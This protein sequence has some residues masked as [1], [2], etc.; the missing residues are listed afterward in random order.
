MS[1]IIREI[2]WQEYDT[3]TQIGTVRADII[4][5]AIADLPS[6]GIMS[7][8]KLDIGSSAK[9]IADGSEWEIQSSGSWVR[10]PSKLQLDL[11]GYVT[12]QDLSDGLAGKVDNTTYSAGQA[13]QDDLI[14]YAID[15]GAKNL[16]NID[17]TPIVNH[18]DYTLTDGKLTVSANG[19]WAHYS[20]P[21]NL[22]AGSYILSTVISGYSKASGAPDTSMRL[23][24]SATTSGGTNV[25]LYTITGNGAI[26]VPFTWTG[27]T[28]YLQFYSN[29][30]TT[31]YANSFVADDVMIRRS[32][33]ADSTYVPYAPTNRELYELIK[34]YHP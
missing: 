26:S 19:N 29:Y 15:T 16:F 5:D 9:V 8:Y 28:I 24:M 32:E 11:T 21:L 6:G 14:N 20:V 17:A 33:I 3:T 7:D 27:G 4:C 12:T 34:S 1:A 30:N 18:T 13:T 25:L 2:F 22:P 10:Q 31:T 23:R